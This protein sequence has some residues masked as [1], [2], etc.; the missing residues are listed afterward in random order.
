MARQNIYI[1]TNDNDGTGDKL[2]D[3]MRKVNENFT[4][5]YTGTAS[6]TNVSITSNKIEVTNSNGNLTLDPNGTGQL[7][8]TTGTTIN[9]GQQP[10]GYFV[11]KAS[12][13][14][15]VIKV[16]PF[17]KNVGINTTANVAGLS[18]AGNA[19]ITGTQINLLA[20][21]YL[22]DI[23][24]RINFDGKVN[25]TVEPFTN[26]TFDLGATGNNWNRIYVSNVVATALTTG[27]AT[28]TT[29]TTTG[30]ITISGE[31]VIGNLVIR[32]N[33]ISNNIVNEDIEI[34]PYGTGNVFVNTKVIIGTGPTPMVNPL[35]QITGNADNFTQVGVQNTNGGKFACSDFV[36]FNDDGSDFYN[37]VD[38]G[39]NN[40][41]WDGSLQYLYFT[42]PSNATSWTVG[43]IVYQVDPSDGSS[44]LAQ[45]T[46]DETIVNPANAAERRIRVCQ[47]HSG[48]TGV[49][50]QGSTAGVVYNTTKGTSATPKDHILQT[51]N[52]TGTAFYN[53]GTDG[54]INSST[55]K[56]AFSPTVIMAADSLVVKV[57]GVLKTPGIDYTVRFSQ[58]EFYNIPPV[59][60]VITLRQ[61]PEANYPF[62]V[63][64]AGDSYV[65]NNGSQLTL[66]TMTGHDLIFHANGSRW[67]AEAGRLKGDTRNWIFG[68]NPTSTA[69]LEDTGEKVQVKGTLALTKEIVQTNR[70][71]SSAVGSAGDKVGMIA[72]DNSYFYRCT[73]NYDGSTLIWK[74]VAFSS[75]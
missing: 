10:A 7:I 63:G 58:I 11:V 24:H 60:T 38:I 30:N 13:G 40:T 21:V 46:I 33:E 1:G 17:Y 16:N 48:T 52:S 32:G 73:G 64:Q 22:G 6:N 12:D 42:I 15:D 54:T 34:K 61:L 70:T 2:R 26:N 23:G 9:S 20:N 56:A 8:V 45:G 44:I 57:D 72:S 69:G 3:A 18:V 74:R 27:N 37:F 41:G 59:G 75:W 29:R 5:L 43:D 71:I 68:S 49:F 28:I 51:I 66:G 19:T 47:V 65:Y 35:L 39:Q 25:S 14:T 67:N 50:E 31:S 36:V 4:E 53:L 55:A 62:T